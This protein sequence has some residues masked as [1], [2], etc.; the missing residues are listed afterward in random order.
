M[1]HVA[2]APAV[3]RTGE[4]NGQYFSLVPELTRN[5][6]YNFTYS[7]SSK[8]ITYSILDPSI[9]T[10]FVV[11]VSG[12]GKMWWLMSATKSILVW[13]QPRDQCDIYSY[14]G[15]FGVCRSI[16]DC[17]SACLS[18]CSCTAYAYGSG[19]FL[20]HGGLVNLQQVSDN[21]SD[22]GSIEDCKSACLSN[23]SCTACA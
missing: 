15:A 6:V 8:Y 19:C 22:M 12:Q 9:V 4:W 5:Q 11:D 1:A 2:A 7:N 10:H 17:K 16:Q 21:S 13:L 23:C 14:C 20:W 18:N 3:R